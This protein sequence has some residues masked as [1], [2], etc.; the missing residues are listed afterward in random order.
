M[1]KMTGQ[2]YKVHTDS[3]SVKIDEKLN[4]CGARGI[5]KRRGEGISVGDIV[6]VRVLSV[7]AKRKR[8][9]LSMKGTDG[10]KL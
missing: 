5:L 9:G 6:R 3:Y 4:K 1:D 8:I 10:R 2:V 7:D